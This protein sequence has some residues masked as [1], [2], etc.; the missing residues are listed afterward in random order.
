MVV[1]TEIQ[2][3]PSKTSGFENKIF[4]TQ[5]QVYDHIIS[6][7]G[8]IPIDQPQLDIDDETRSTSY[9]FEEAAIRG[10]RQRNLMLAKDD[11]EWT[12]ACIVLGSAHL[13][14]CHTK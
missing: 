5:Q 1:L 7:T 8:L 10:I 6:P 3:N 4:F 12:S 9:P 2:A 11:L 14:R 13:Q